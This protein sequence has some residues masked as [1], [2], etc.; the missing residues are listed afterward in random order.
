MATNFWSQYEVSRS[1]ERTGT[2]R[3]FEG[4]QICAILSTQVDAL[5]PQ[6]DPALGAMHYWPGAGGALGAQLTKYHLRP[7]PGRAAC[8]ELILTYRELQPEAALTPGRAVLY[9]EVGGEAYKAKT[10]KGAD[11]SEIL[12]DGPIEGEPTKRW[13]IVSGHNIQFSPMCKLKV[14]TCAEPNNVNL[15]LDMFGKTNSAPLSNIGNAPAYTV[16]FMGAVESGFLI[17]NRYWK[18]EYHFVYKKG[19][20]YNTMEVQK[21]SKAPIRVPLVGTDG[22]VIAG[23]FRDIIGWLP[24]GNK[25]PCTVVTEAADFSD[26]N[27]RLGWY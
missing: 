9:V 24:E 21:M 3:T 5:A 8:H 20:W 19:G 15:M 22:V 6:Y 17:N 23:Q 1:G 26:L 14:V 11:G 27:G 4:V 16:K 25:I 7:Y 10:V 13:K 18:I 2:L 12:V